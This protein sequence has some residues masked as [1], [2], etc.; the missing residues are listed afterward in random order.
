MHIFFDPDGEKDLLKVCRNY[1][2]NEKSRNRITQ[3]NKRKKNTITST[4]HKRQ[5]YQLMMQWNLIIIEHSP[6]IIRKQENQL[7]KGRNLLI[8]Q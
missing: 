3:Q 4:M 2:I 8:K 5:K 1:T 6:S 7:V